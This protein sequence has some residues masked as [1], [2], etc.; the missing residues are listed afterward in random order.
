[1]ADQISEEELLDLARKFS[2]RSH[3]D[4]DAV[5]GPFMVWGRGSVVRD[6]NQV[7]ERRKC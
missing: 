5:P 7:F 3:M 1:M 2:F 6:V 4:R